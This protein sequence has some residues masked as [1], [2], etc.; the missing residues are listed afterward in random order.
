MQPMKDMCMK[1][2]VNVCYDSSLIKS[3]PIYN[4]TALNITPPV[5]CTTGWGNISV[6]TSG[7]YIGSNGNDTFDITGEEGSSSSRTSMNAFFSASITS[8][9]GIDTFVVHPISYSN[10]VITDFKPNIDKIDLS[11]TSSDSLNITENPTTINLA[12]DQSVVLLNI[13]KTQLNADD[14]KFSGIT[15]NANIT[16]LSDAESPNNN[17]ITH[18][19]YSYLWLMAIPVGLCVIA[20]LAAS[21]TA[22]YKHFMHRDKPQN[23]QE[24]MVGMVVHTAI[25][26]NGIMDSHL[27]DG[28]RLG[29]IPLPPPAYSPATHYTTPFVHHVPMEDSPLQF[30]ELSELFPPPALPLTPL[31]DLSGMAVGGEC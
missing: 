3:I 22:S 27:Q 19:D 12:N 28:P 1:G 29:H 5:A 13:N 24:Q 17:A 16:P 20:A 2:C 14:F 8:R 30:P 9:K 23:H 11:K 6:Q 25:G 10:I 31:Q 26:I 15:L 7:C 21:A 4:L 18:S